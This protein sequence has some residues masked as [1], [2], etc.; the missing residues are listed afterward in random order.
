MKSENYLLALHEIITLWYEDTQTTKTKI[1]KKL[2]LILLF[3][4][5]IGFGQDDKIIFISGDTIFGKV[6]EVGVNDITYQYKDETTN[7]ISKK[8][9]LAKVIYSSGRTETF[10]GLMVKDFQEKK[11]NNQKVRI[12][13]RE[14]RR[15]AVFS[16]GMIG[17]INNANIYGQDV[18]ETESKTGLYL[19]AFV[20][21]NYLGIKWIPEIIFQQ[22]GMKKNVDGFFDVSNVLEKLQANYIT[23][24][25]NASFEIADIE[26]AVGP[27]VSYAITGESIVWDFPKTG[28]VY[29]RNIS[30]KDDELF[31][32]TEFGGKLEVSY[33]INN[34]LQICVDYEISL[35]PIYRDKEQERSSVSLP[36]SPSGDDPI[37]TPPLINANNLSAFWDPEGAFY[38]SVFKFGFRYRLGDIL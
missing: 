19:G 28:N 15:N 36:S 20:T 37:L 16:F 8:R 5:M 1:M 29:T 34:H 13:K 35:T 33:Y 38:Y 4:P 30:I 23:L 26:F 3:L 2:L 32:R 6:I 24:G 12:Q 11:Y 27:C 22:K 17:G 14:E 7:N 31:S 25:V 9:E 18:K 10:E 21:K